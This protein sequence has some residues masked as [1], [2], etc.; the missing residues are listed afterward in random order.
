L[1]EEAFYRAGDFDNGAI[2]HLLIGA[3][4][5]AVAAYF[6]HELERG[7]GDFVARGGLVGDSQDFNAAAHN[8]I[9]CLTRWP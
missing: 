7:G 3:R 1:V 4:G 9:L 8:F 6:A 2:E 5:L